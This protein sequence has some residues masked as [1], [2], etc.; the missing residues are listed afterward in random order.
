MPGKLLTVEF[1]SQ[2][3]IVIPYDT[4]FGGKFRVNRFEVVSERGIDS[5][6][7]LLQ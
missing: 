6:D 3:T 1:T 4:S 7:E 2:D 5:I